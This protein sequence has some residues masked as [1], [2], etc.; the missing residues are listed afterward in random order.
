MVITDVRWFID[1]DAS[2]SRRR[3]R[4][5]TVQRVAAFPNRLVSGDDA[6]NRSSASSSGGTLTPLASISSVAATGRPWRRR[7]C[8]E[9]TLAARATLVGPDD[10]RCHCCQ[11]A[12]LSVRE[13]ASTEPTPDGSARPDG[14]QRLRASSSLVRL[15][16]GATKAA[17][18]GHTA[19]PTR[20]STPQP[21]ASTALG[22]LPTVS[23]ERHVAA[24]RD[25][26]GDA[27]TGHV[28]P[29]PANAGTGR[30]LLPPAANLG[31]RRQWGRRQVHLRSGRTYEP[32]GR[33][34]STP[35]RHTPTPPTTRACVGDT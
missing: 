23:P 33:T 25:L 22:C 9:Q 10:A 12:G 21:Q 20:C 29:L 14:N 16:A 32:R 18:L 24:P 5:T 2:T 13:L 4:S 11:G 6:S 17:Q 26:L 28:S 30:R 3:V 34:R 8:V 19:G 35:G 31:D 1:E 7:L 15:A 27:P